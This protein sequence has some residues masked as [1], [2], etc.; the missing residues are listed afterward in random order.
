M[1]NDIVGW[2]ISIV[3]YICCCCIFK[4]LVGCVNYYFW[5]C[6]WILQ[7]PFFPFPDEMHMKSPCT[8][9]DQHRHHKPVWMHLLCQGFCQWDS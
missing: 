3:V 8:E 5:R 1:I 9:R 6:G 2:L 4:G 7:P